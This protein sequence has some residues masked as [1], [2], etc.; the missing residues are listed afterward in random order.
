MAA[1][2]K[3]AVLGAGKIGY[4]HIRGFRNH[5]AAEVAALV[6][7]SE[8]RLAVCADEY[9]ITNRSTDYREILKMDDID[10][11]SIGLPN[12]LHKE[13][14]VAAL[15]AGK[16]VLLEKP[17]A[18]NCAEAREI[19]K[20][21]EKNKRLLMVGQNHRFDENSQI[22]KYYIDKGDIGDPYHGRA[23]YLRK[24]GI[25]KMGT[26]FTLKKL[27]GGG[28][29]IDIGVHFLDLIFYLMGT[30]DVEAVSASVFGTFG[31]R[32]IGGGTWGLSDEEESS[33]RFDVDDYAASLIKLKGGKSVIMETS[34]HAYMQPEHNLTILGTEG[35]ARV[36]P[37]EIQRRNGAICETISSVD[38]EK[39]LPLPTDKIVHFVDCIVKEDVEP[40]VKVEESLMVQRVLDAVYESSETGREVR[41]QR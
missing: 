6:D 39:G 28:A 8:E 24:N 33:V 4:N 40:I 23:Y 20:A 14:A 26:W 22:V 3:A 15:N 1:K 31:P 13:T 30:F 7:K 11:V 25:P 2:V 10:I 37:V 32:D 19:V 38:M 18:M 12:F 5:P 36:N 9:D 17:M 35:G 16:H 34:W 21:A 27:S 41:L 29:V